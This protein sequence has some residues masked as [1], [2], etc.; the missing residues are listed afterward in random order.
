LVR[1]QDAALWVD[2][3]R[4][5][6]QGGDIEGGYTALSAACVLTPGIGF[7]WSALAG[8]MVHNGSNPSAIQMGLRASH[9]APTPGGAVNLAGAYRR[10]GLDQLADHWAAIALALDPS[11]GPSWDFLS[12]LRQAMAPALAKRA[13]SR[14][15]Q[16]SGP[17]ALLY[18]NFAELS[19]RLNQ[20]EIAS[21]FADKALALDP[22]SIAP[23]VILA[24]VAMA[25][26]DW[27]PAVTILAQAL[28]FDPADMGAAIAMATAAGR[29]SAYQP[30]LDWSARA[31]QLL[32][33]NALAWNACGI[34]QR[35]VGAAH[36]SFEAF[37][38]AA[39]LAPDISAASSN[40]VLAACYLPEDPARDQAVLER[41]ARHLPVACRPQAHD[42]TP[43]RPLR[44][45]Y[46]SADFR[47]HPVGIFLA[48]VLEN[49]DQS[50]VLPILYA[51]QTLQDKMTV[52]L[53]Q[54]APIRYVSGLDDAALAQVIRN[55]GVD[56]LVDLSGHTGGNRLGVM[57]RRPAP[58]MLTW[59]GLVGSSGLSFIDGILADPIQIPPGLAST[60]AEPVRYLTPDYACF[61]PPTPAP[62]IGPSPGQTNR[63]LMFGCLNNILK[64][65]DQT[66]DLWAELLKFMPGSQ[67]ILKG[68]G[69]DFP[70][71]QRR[72]CARFS[73]HG[74]DPT[75]LILEGPA[76]SFEFLA[77]YGR[78]DIALDPIPYSGGLTTMEALWMGVPVLTLPGRRFTSR[79]SAAHLTAIGLENWIAR[80]EADYIARAYEF[81]RDRSGLS[82][83]RS[84]LRDR[85]AQSALCDGASMARQVEA[86]YQDLW[87]DLLA[88]Q[89]N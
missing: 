87:A 65:T 44:I 10:A 27:R 80:D 29:C 7:I 35:L 25:K 5:S 84:G 62:P 60:Y 13:I 2:A 38:R 33:D 68:P 75:R 14:A 48:P 67:L 79:H 76:S 6:L 32:P 28:A 78:I 41:F 18:S 21:E 63:D 22:A 77:T 64:I 61:T 36:A 3:A 66:I 47:Q 85:M 88:G 54:S 24:K 1:G 70:P 69:F 72:L 20:S 17:N 19:L 58:I 83:L 73:S 50:I 39:D 56:V 89:L 57:A 34:A 12:Q 51:S 74:V 71:V 45:G 59:G 40:L 9:L 30:A 49:H 16:S 11:L 46:L 43:N 8:L 53:A 15:L 31:V 86:I 81:S 55:D 37:L 26:M 82:R 23:R 52:R 4:L 42:P